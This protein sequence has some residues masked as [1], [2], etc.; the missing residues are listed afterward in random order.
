MVCRDGFKSHSCDLTAVTPENRKRLEALAKEDSLSVGF[1]AGTTDAGLAS[2][3]TVPWVEHISLFADTPLDLA[4]LRQLTKLKKL[5]VL[6]PATCL[7]NPDD[8]G[9]LTKL[10]ELKMHGGSPRTLDLRTLG[11][12]TKVKELSA[13]DWDLRGLASLGALPALES[14]TL[15]GAKVDDLP[16]LGRL[17]GLTLLSIAKVTGPSTSGDFAWLANVTQLQY[18]YLD[19]TAITTLAPLVGMASLR[20]LSFSFTRVASLEPLKDLRRLET[21]S[22]VDSPVTDL[23]P[24]SGMPVLRS[25][26]IN[27]ARVT[28]LEPIAALP[29]LVNLEAHYTKITDLGPLRQAKKLEHLDIDGTHVR[30]VAPLAFCPQLWDLKIRGTSVTDLKPLE[31]VAHLHRLRPPDSATPAQLGALQKKFPELVI[32]PVEPR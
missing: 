13:Y 25:L 16:S 10:E 3:A 14:V 8:L 1:L 5:D 32:E 20:E 6:C 24:L 26:V 12:L 19:D 22:L 23:A 2:I 15:T 30:S 11:K 29:R 18:L 7:A 9:A 27:G 17:H 4:P 31:K 21:L 28:S